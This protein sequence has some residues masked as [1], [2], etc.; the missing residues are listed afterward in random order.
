M[1]HRR[2]LTLHLQGGPRANALGRQLQTM[3]GYNPATSTSD[4]LKGQ[5]QHQSPTEANSAPYR[6]PC[7]EAPLLQFQPVLKADW[8]G[9]QFLPVMSKSIK[10]QLQQDS[11]HIHIG[12]NLEHPAQV[13]AEAVSQGPTR[14]THYTRPPYL[15]SRRCS[16]SI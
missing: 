14:H 15:K 10:I 13:T 9:G 7:T 1:E 12:E 6:H 4:T 16:S 8:P 2:H 5:T 3:P 11:V